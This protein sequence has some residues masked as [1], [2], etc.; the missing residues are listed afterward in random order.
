MVNGKMVRSVNPCN[1]E[2][3][4]KITNNVK[5][6][7]LHRLV[8]SAIKRDVG[9][10]LKQSMNGIFNTNTKFNLDFYDKPLAY[11]TDGETEPTEITGSYVYRPDGTIERITNITGMD[12]KITLNSSTLP[13]STEEYVT[14]TILHEALHAYFKSANT[15]FDHDIMVRKYIPWYKASLH[16]I[17]PSMTEGDLTGLAYG[18]LMQEAAF[19]TSSEYAM[20]S[21][22]EG[23]NDSYKHARSGIPCH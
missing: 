1:V 6:P 12:I 18:G 23:V 19:Q 13:N 16:A 20:K 14:A 2:Q 11:F 5:D 4:A 21:L 7:C 10:E 22:Y 15:T 9:Y 3:A 8:D 17:Y